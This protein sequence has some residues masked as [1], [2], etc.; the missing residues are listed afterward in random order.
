ML[1][2]PTHLP[3]N[4]PGRAA[5]T[6]S[7]AQRCCPSAAPAPLRAELSPA[8]GLPA[9][10]REL[11]SPAILPQP[12]QCTVHMY[13]YIRNHHQFHS[14]THTTTAGVVRVSAAPIMHRLHLQSGESH[15]MLQKIALP[16]RALHCSRRANHE[17]TVS[18]VVDA[19]SLVV[20]KV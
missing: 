13:K 8:Q 10:A 11:C 7:G 5:P 14:T 6:I 17:R 4:P 20:W 3:T 18:L 12:A 9:T 19:C 16:H 1:P 2:W 15:T